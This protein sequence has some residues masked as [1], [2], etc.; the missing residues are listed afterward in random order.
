MEIPYLPCNR[1]ETPASLNRGRGS[2]FYMFLY[3]I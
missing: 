3:E 1:T 2:K